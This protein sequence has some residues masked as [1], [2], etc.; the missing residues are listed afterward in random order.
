MLVTPACADVITG[1]ATPQAY[2]L[3]QS[4][5]AGCRQIAESKTQLNTSTQL[6]SWLCVG[7]RNKRRHNW[8]TFRTWSCIPQPNV[9]S[10]LRLSHTIWKRITMSSPGMWSWQLGATREQHQGVVTLR[11]N[12]LESSLQLQYRQLAQVTPLYEP[13]LSLWTT[14]LNDPPHHARS[15]L[16]YGGVCDATTS[17]ADF[18]DGIDHRVTSNQNAV[19]AEVSHAAQRM[20]AALRIIETARWQIGG[21]NQHMERDSDLKGRVRALTDRVARLREGVQALKASQVIQSFSLKGDQTDA[22]ASSPCLPVSTVMRPEGRQ[23]SGTPE[24][25]S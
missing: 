13:E 15:R 16:N 3:R 24:W 25:P 4:Y 10:S 11:D 1:E 9:G 20:E 12:P 8:R 21:I 5:P 22:A 19:A 18:I 6:W 7:Q 2:Y 14:R 17:V 23:F